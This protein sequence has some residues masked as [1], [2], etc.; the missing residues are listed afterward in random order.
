[1]TVIGAALWGLQ[2]TVTQGLLSA[3]VADAAPEHLRGTAF[4]IYELAVG[5][6]TFVA[7]AT[8]GILWMV[9]GPALTCGV[10]AAVAAVAVVVLLLR[11]MPNSVA[12]P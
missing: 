6:A 2:L 8:A 11:P 7:S 9:G 12:I 5:V 1:M 4:G 3:S 10:S